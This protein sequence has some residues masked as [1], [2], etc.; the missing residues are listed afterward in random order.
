MTKS[1]LT[2]IIFTYNHVDS[3]A[4][5]IESIV[6][7]KTDYK[8]EIHIC[9]DAS[10]DGTSEICKKYAEKYPDKIKYFLQ[11]ENTFLYPYTKNHLT[12][13]IRRINT[14]YFCIIDG[15]DYWCSEDKIQA[16]LDFL[17]ANS[18]Y[19]GWAHDTLQVNK[20]ED[21]QRSYIHE[22]CKLDKIDN[23]VT[24]DVNAPFLLTSSRIFRNVGFAKI[25]ISPVDYLMYYYHLSKGPIYYDDKIRAAYVMSRNSCFA[26]LPNIPDLYAMYPYKLSKLFKFKQDD[27]C[28]ELL[29]IY[30]D[31]H[32]KG[33]KRY[34]K[35][36]RFK[37]FLG[38]KL[39]WHLWFLTTFVPKFGFEC[40]DINF[41]YPLKTVH[42]AAKSRVVAKK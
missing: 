13:A 7:Q 39:G 1:L 29:R 37:R 6:N 10:I 14:K 15:D 11:K 36:K 19:I 9:D 38:K 35:L 17:E 31:R 18:D 28:M 26:N 16:A 41:I 23:P 42:N 4:K 40:M 27:F 34:K 24:F 2:A 8:Y 20:N 5:C 32:G 33:D 12:Q 30:D 3:I 25:G 22:V 21:L